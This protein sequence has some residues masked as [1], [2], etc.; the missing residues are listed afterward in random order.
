MWKASF[1]GGILTGILFIGGRIILKVLL[2]KGNVGTLYG[3][4]SSVMLV[5]LFVFYS[6]FI[7][8][9]GA[10][11]IKIYSD[12]MGW[13]LAFHKKAAKGSTQENAAVEG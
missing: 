10:C 1:L 9:F 4:S 2:I 3:T 8:Y 7:L 11:F 12:K 13:A 5:L 6:S